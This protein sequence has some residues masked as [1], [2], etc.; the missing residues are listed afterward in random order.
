MADKLSPNFSVGVSLPLCSGCPPPP[1]RWEASKLPEK[2]PLPLFLINTAPAHDYD[3]HYHGDHHDHDDCLHLTWAIMVHLQYF[4]CAV[5][6]NAL[7]LLSPELFFYFLLSASTVALSLH[8]FSTS[9]RHMA[10]LTS[11]CHGEFY[12][13]RWIWFEDWR[14]ICKLVLSSIAFYDQS[15]GI[16]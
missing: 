5:T 3:Y 13:K 1:A 6:R 12:G 2:L 10:H 4:S 14:L 8:N 7:N 15:F 9:S 11:P 16:V